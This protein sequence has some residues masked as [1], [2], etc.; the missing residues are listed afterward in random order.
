MST[1]GQSTANRGSSTGRILRFLTLFVLLGP[2]ALVFGVDS[3]IND[4]R[5]TRTW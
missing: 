1:C 2:F 4:E 5:D 3:R